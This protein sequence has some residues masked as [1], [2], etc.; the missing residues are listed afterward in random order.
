MPC[1]TIGHV[2]MTPERTI[3]NRSSSTC[4]CRHPL[5]PQ[6]LPSEPL[7]CVGANPAWGSFA[8]AKLVG[9]QHAYYP[10]S[11]GSAR[12][13]WFQTTGDHRQGLSHGAWHTDVDMSASEPHGGKS[14]Q[15]LSCKTPTVETAMICTSQERGLDEMAEPA[16]FPPMGCTSKYRTGPREREGQNFPDGPP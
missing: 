2:G 14:W 9:I 5:A 15:Y 13:I 16:G 4:T 1:R 11:R 12:H 8:G 10:T 3:S 7:R 6:K